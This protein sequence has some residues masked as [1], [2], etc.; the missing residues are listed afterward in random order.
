[1]Y[2]YYVYNMSRF[3]VC[4]VYYGLSLGVGTLSNY[5][6]C[7]SKG[8]YNVALYNMNLH[9]NRKKTI[10]ITKVV[11]RLRYTHELP[12]FPTMKARDN[13]H[14]HYIEIE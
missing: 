12:F 9:L 13:D 10:Q 6:H 7:Q 8:D 5:E 14:T 1:M 4:M 11:L 2:V 3:T